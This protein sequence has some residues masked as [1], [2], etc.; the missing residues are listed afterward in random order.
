ENHW[1]EWRLKKEGKAEAEA[2]FAAEQ[3]RLFHLIELLKRDG[4]ADLALDAVTN[5]ELRDE[6]YRE[7]HIGE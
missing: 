3:K 5:Q 4:K 7:Y 1:E 6:L 2:S